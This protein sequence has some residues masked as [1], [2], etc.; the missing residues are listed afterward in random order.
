MNI[1][2][3]KIIISLLLFILLEYAICTKEQILFYDSS[4]TQVEPSVGKD[5]LKSLKSLTYDAVRDVFYFTDR[6]HP[7]TSIFSLK[8]RND[9]SFIVEPLVPRS[10]NEV[11]QDLVYDFHD[12]TLYYSDSKNNKIV[13][14]IFDRS[15][16]IKWSMQTFVANLADVSGLEIDSC[17]RNLYYTITTEKNP[18][19]NRVSLLLNHTSVT[20]FGNEN[21]YQP[22]AIAMD[23][24]KRRLY[25]GDIRKYQ[26]YSVDSLSSDGKEFRT[27]IKNSYKTPRSI[28]VDAD[29]VYYVEGSDHELR[30]F[31]KDGDKK[32]SEMF[33]DLPF[34]PSDIIVRSNFITDLDP[35]LC[36]VSQE[37]IESAKKEIAKNTQATTAFK[38]C[39][40]GGS[41][42]KTTSN[43]RCMENF[44]G[45]YCEINLCYNFCL[46][47]DC[48]MDRSKINGRLEPKCSCKTGF[49]GD[50]CEIDVCSNFCLNG[51]TCGVDVSRTAKCECAEGFEGE[52]CESHQ[53]EKSITTSTTTTEAATSSTDKITTTEEAEIQ[54][55]NILK[56]NGSEF[57]AEPLHCTTDSNNITYAIVAVCT[58]ISLLI[59]LVIL[60]VIKKLNKPLRP[61]IKKKYVLHK[62]IEPLTQRPTTDHCEV[63]IEDCCNMNICETVSSLNTQHI[64]RKIKFLF[65][66]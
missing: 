5:G 22:T 15:K 44:D 4:W 6:K 41:L 43:C 17:K 21:H 53:V 38:V 19:I 26:S 36:K 35:K 64:E 66:F 11:I 23:H 45:D 31:K 54:H 39:L 3:N 65:R 51:G 28:A 14:L 8:I 63:V 42:D 25:V 37:K 40:H 60:V 2:C 57:K 55:G 20:T 34:D 9:T 1:S 32:T 61:R 56:L 49:V 27:E 24:Q 29:Y 18:S 7:V 52:R 47:G 50:H 62:N 48:S 10:E 59:V 12:D 58:M 30:R 33:K 16:N 13:K 46:N